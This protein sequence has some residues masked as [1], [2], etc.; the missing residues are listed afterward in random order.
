[1][2]VFPEAQEAA[3]KEIDR[4]IGSDRLPELGDRESLPYISAI[5]K[6]VWR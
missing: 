5:M 6:E 2:L 4:V 1:M 3:Q